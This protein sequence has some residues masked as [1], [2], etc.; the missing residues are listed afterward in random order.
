MERPMVISGHALIEEDLTLRSVDIIIERGIIIAIEETDKSPDIWICPALFNAHTHLGDTIAMDCTTKGDLV[1]L[2]TPPN[3]LKHR[4]LATASRK[5]IVTGMKTS[6]GN[7]INHG[8]AGCVDFRE[9]G[10]DGVIALREAAANQPFR[11]V[12][13]G[14]DGG[15]ID[16][17]GLGVSSVRDIPDLDRIVAKAKR[18]GK[19]VAFH[20]GEKDSKDVDAA[21]A[22]DPNFI[23]HATHATNK[24]LKQCADLSIPI[25]VCP[26]S[27][28]TLDATSSKAHPPIERM[29]NLGCT[30]YLGTDNV[31]FV[32]PDM[33][34]EMAFV[35]TIY[36]L[37]PI[38]TLQ[39]AISGS[40]IKG[41][42]F[43][44]KTGTRANLFLINPRFSNLRFSQHP[45]ASIVKR[46]NS[47]IIGTNVFNS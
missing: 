11:C 16:S 45:V 5:D 13:F 20:A 17:D 42:P 27:N 6:I 9:G 1:E 8:T 38:I 40:S 14:R 32:E 34:T 35:H 26:R 12:I 19:Q 28:W 10:S 33:F 30:V 47:N 15:E 44:I 7:M 21:L 43:F 2:V 39:M 31:M 18:N 3:G 4:L 29:L 22:Y 37:D 41:E 23:I 46:A 25:V 24:Q 36:R